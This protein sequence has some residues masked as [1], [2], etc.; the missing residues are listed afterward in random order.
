MPPVWGSRGETIWQPVL[1]C[2]I[3]RPFPGRRKCLSYMSP[4][5]T[6][7][8]TWGKMITYQSQSPTPRNCLLD[9]GWVSSITTA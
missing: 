9:L 3:F 6:K 7:V 1:R 5:F 2:G 4:L 8:V